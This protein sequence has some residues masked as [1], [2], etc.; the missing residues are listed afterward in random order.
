[1]SG[2]MPTSAMVLAAGLGTRMRAANAAL[3]KP[4]MPCAGKP[5]I[6]HALD[7]LAAAGVRSAVV[8]SHYL[9]DLLTAHIMDYAARHPE[10]AIRMSP[11]AELL[12]TG[13][14]VANALP[15]LGAEAFFVLNSDTV[16]QDG[17]RA[18]ARLAAAW[19]DGRMDA[20]L[21]LCPRDRA[22]GHAGGGPERAHGAE[23]AHIFCGVQ[24]LHPRLFEGAPAGPYS[25]NRHYDAAA[26]AGRLFALEHDSWWYH[27]GTPEALAEAERRLGAAGD[28]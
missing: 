9:A 21:L 16:L 13:G 28:G 15:H 25:L 4:L 22:V 19:D 11:E 3:P 2:D 27:V 24:M 7:R 8:N 20:L 17:A 6:D 23:D 1:M 14:G 18:L 5:L 12:D 26:Q 10:L